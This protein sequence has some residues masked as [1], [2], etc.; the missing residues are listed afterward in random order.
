MIKDFVLSIIQQADPVASRQT[1]EADIALLTTAEGRIERELEHQPELALQMRRAIGE[2]YGNR[3]EYRRAREVLRGAITQARMTLPPDNLELIGA[4]VQMADEYVIDSPESRA[5]L[6][7]AITR[8]R[9]LGPE[10]QPLLADALLARHRSMRWTAKWTDV[11]DTAREAY[12]VARAIGDE[13]RV[14]VATADLGYALLPL[15][16]DKE[17]LQAIAE[18]WDFGTRSGRI[19]PA[20]PRRIIAMAWYGFSVCRAGQQPEGLKLGQQAVDDARKYH[21]SSSRATEVALGTLG[22]TFDECVGDPKRALEPAREAYAITVKREPPESENRSFRQSMLTNVLFELG[23]H[24]E[25]RQVMRETPVEA[26]RGSGSPTTTPVLNLIYEADVYLRLGDTQTAERLA[27]EALLAMQVAGTQAQAE[28]VY[29]VLAQALHENGKPDRAETFAVASLEHVELV[30]SA[31][32][33]ASKLLRLGRIRLVLGKYQSALELADQAL[34]LYSEKGAP[35]AGQFSQVNYQRG[36]AL[37]GLGRHQEAVEDL[38][39]SYDFTHKSSPGSLAEARLAYWYG[40]ALIANGESARGRPLVTAASPRL[41][42]S[43]VYLDRAL[44]AG[45]GKPGKSQR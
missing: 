6:E 34:A 28:R 12:R 42:A 45:D 14:L 35:G 11:V 18:A 8:L 25:V 43:H 1:R 20:D 15:E 23:L 32:G 38:A 22:F 4:M 37:L 24:D 26:S 27:E 36:R 10:A 13:G 40:Q 44:V 7:T 19:E 2:A 41:A 21:G 3:G 33:H 17:L 29:G 16:D 31:S 39:A 30:T 5:D 9:T